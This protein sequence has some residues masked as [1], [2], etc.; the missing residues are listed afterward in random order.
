MKL[1]DA[2]Q[3][4]NN[5]AGLYAEYPWLILPCRIRLTDGKRNYVIVYNTF[6]EDLEEMMWEDLNLARGDEIPEYV[7]SSRFYK[8][9]WNNLIDLCKQSPYWEAW[10][11]DELYHFN[12]QDLRNAPDTGRGLIISNNIRVRRT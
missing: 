6:H 9:D 4:R 8:T 7:L 1:E 10:S 12:C 3:V 2:I 5:K 11:L